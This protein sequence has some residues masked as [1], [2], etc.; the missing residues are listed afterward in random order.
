MYSRYGKRN[1]DW[2]RLF[3]SYERA[4]L[5]NLDLR[6]EELSPMVSNTRTNSL[7]DILR[8]DPIR[9]V[10]AAQSA[11]NSD[12]PNIDGVSRAVILTQMMLYDRIDGPEQDGK[13][14]ALRRHWYAYF[15][16]FAQLFA[17]AAGKTR[18]NADGN[19]EMVDLQWSG[20]LSKIYA[21]FVDNGQVTYKDLWV[22]DSSRMMKIFDSWGRL[23]RGF[24]L[25]VC[26]EKDSL[27]SDFVD[28][29]QNMGALAIISGKGKNSKAAAELMLRKLGWQEND[30][31]TD[32][33][34]YQTIVIHLSDHDFDGESVIGPTFGEQL[35][36][37]L[38]N[39]V[40]ARI[41]VKPEQVEATVPD[42]WIAS[43][44]VKTSNDGYRN[45]A[46]QK[47]LFWAECPKC[48]HLQ[49]AIGAIYKDGEAYYESNSVCSQCLDSTLIVH[50][51]DY[52]APHGFE[53]E[54]LRSADYYEQIVEAVLE[55]IDFSDIVYELRSECVPESY[56]IVGTMRDKYLETLLQY[57]KIESAISTL[58][59][60]KY[61]LQQ[62]FS[63][64]IDEPVVE[65][66]RQTKS[67]WMYT[68]PD[69]SLDQLKAH[70]RT[71]YGTPWRPFNKHQ[72]ETIV[73]EVLEED[74]ELL[75]R[76]SAI[77]LDDWNDVVDAVNT[78]LE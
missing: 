49:Y 70:I 16:Q 15:K 63:A 51:D 69:P 4:F 32:L 24:N 39:V 45:W 68:E 28:A 8:E 40:E 1:T 30:T 6:L 60:A 37:Y 66:I 35:R 27:F 61:R 53:V 26:V 57:Q 19:D 46:D 74:S 41:G 13:P 3:G 42:A 36:R 71:T 7:V 73:V 76:I 20:R 34:R 54:S 47:A 50:R 56:S 38:P 72:R 33:Y 75:E 44:Q 67:D 65:T 78:A 31:D 64:Q 29:A 52:E 23:F 77:S 18:K 5:F 14:K 9:F 2:E 59:D 43:Y 12:K 11:N 55:H 58:E 22:E 48:G 17:F 62:L 10:K 25:I 21:G